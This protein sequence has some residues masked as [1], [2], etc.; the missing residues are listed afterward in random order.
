MEDKY[1]PFHSKH[2]KNKSKYT[3]Q[4]VDCLNRPPEKYETENIVKNNINQAQNSIEEDQKNLKKIASEIPL[5][6]EKDW[7]EPS[8]SKI[9][10]EETNE[11][12]EMNLSEKENK[13][14]KL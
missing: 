12:V 13:K 7:N 8:T 2:H 1:K 5:F 11:S 10:T 6:K 4:K 14:R 3:N 9:K